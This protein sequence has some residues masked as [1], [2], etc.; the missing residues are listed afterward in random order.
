MEF[1]TF[2]LLAAMFLSVF[3]FQLM[4]NNFDFFPLNRALSLENEEDTN[5]QR[6]EHLQQQIDYLVAKMK[7][8]VRFYDCK[9]FNYIRIRDMPMLFYQI[10]VIQVYYLRSHLKMGQYFYC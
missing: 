7:D 2:P 9:I 4:I 6:M 5:E 3:Y 8:Q 10:R 1:S